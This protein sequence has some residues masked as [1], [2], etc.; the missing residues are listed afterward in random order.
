M[1]KIINLKTFKR[2]ETTEDFS[3]EIVENASDV[4]SITPEEQNN[5]ESVLDNIASWVLIAG[6]F[7]LPIF[8]LPSLEIPIENGKAVFLATLVVIVFILWLLARLREGTFSIPRIP[9]LW[10]IEGVLAVFLLATIFSPVFQI[11]LSGFVYEKGTLVSMTLLF[12]LLFLALIVFQDKKKVFYVYTALFASF[13]FLF[14]FHLGRFFFGVDFLSFGIF[15]NAVS[16]MV[17]KWND[18]AIFSGL[19]ATLSLFFLEFARV[20][21]KIIKVSLYTA[22]VFSLLILAVVNFFLVWVL[23]GTTALV[24]LV[25]NLSFSQFVRGEGVGEKMSLIPVVVLLV[26]VLFFVSGDS[27]STTISGYANINQIEVRPSWGAT[28]TITKE[29]WSEDLFLGSGPNRFFN[30]WLQFKPAEINNGPFWNTDFNSGIGLIPTFFVTTGLL[31]GI[32]WFVFFAL[33]LIA[34]FRGLF[35]S[36]SIS[37]RY[38]M[39]S[40]FLGALYLWIVSIF[41]VPSLTLF[42]FA[43]LFTGIFGALLIREKIYKNFVFSVARDPRIGFVSVLAMIVLLIGASLGGYAVFQKYVS[44][45]SLREGRIAFNNGDLSQSE[46]ALQKA[47]NANSTDNLYRLL[48]DVKIAKL[49][50]IFSQQ[51]GSIDSIRQEF[52]KTLGEAISVGKNA[53][54]FDKTNYSNWISLGKVYSAVVP[55]NIEGSYDRAD[56]SFKRAFEYNPQSPAIVFEQARLEALRGNNKQARTYLNKVLSMRSGHADAIFLLA[57]IEINEGN[58]GAAIASLER[59]SLID[60]NNVGL[61]FRLGLLRYNNGNYQG[62]ITALERAVEL[63]KDYS[64][65]KY[66]LGLSYYNVGRNDDALRQFEDIEV[67]NPNN[68]EVKKIIENLRNKEKPFLGIIPPGEFPEDREEPPIEE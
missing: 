68:A 3:E 38:F 66:F 30:Q 46:T 36:K 21:Q 62:T 12:I 52:Q 25:Y 41:Y 28:Y 26:A 32:A 9:L 54:E 60:P 39:F 44:L 50:D 1:F 29:T 37:S 17:G 56:E 63:S 49:N 4:V 58:V 6:T 19:I 57:Q 47:I 2:E 48:V 35:A 18:L 11:S 55:L 65:A 20:E 15:T 43:F 34:G 64:N 42:A 31:G 40:S 16:N 53:V 45:S 67:L 27:L 23:V 13:A 51:G 22:L 59:A 10:G 14:L 7:L 5:K 33:F 8:F 61:F 24:I